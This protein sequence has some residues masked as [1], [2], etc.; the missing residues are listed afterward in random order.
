[1]KE[2]VTRIMA[3]ALNGR[4]IEPSWDTRENVSGYYVDGLLIEKVKW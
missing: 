4:S 1:V 3:V 2:S